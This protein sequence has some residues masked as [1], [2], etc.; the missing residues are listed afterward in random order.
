MTIQN[1]I[2]AH[3]LAITKYCE[4]PFEHGV[5]IATALKALDIPEPILDAL[6]D[7]YNMAINIPASKSDEVQEK[8]ISLND[9]LDILGVLGIKHRIAIFLTSE[10]LEELAEKQAEA[11]QKIIKSQEKKQSKNHKESSKCSK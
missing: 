3:E 2:Q 9:F 4:P 5:T 8:S 6:L 1:T 10:S 11:I 7:K